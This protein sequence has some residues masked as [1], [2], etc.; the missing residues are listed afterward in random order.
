MRT[1]G[2]LAVAIVSMGAVSV[3]QEMPAFPP[4]APEHELLERFVGV[5]EM[6][7]ECGDG[8]GG[9]SVTNI[10]VI[11]GR[12]LGERWIVNEIEIEVEG[13]RVVGL[14]TIGFDPA[15]SKYVGTWSDSVQN[16]LWVYEGEYDPATRTLTLSTEGPNLMGDGAMAPFRDTYEF[17]DDDHIVSRSSALGED[18]QWV[19]FMSSDMRRKPE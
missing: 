17:V 4:S 11:R 9:A 13:S 14:Q 3:A 15:R 10:G 8:S 6:E 5:W 16:H 1:H 2:L 18:G 12:M 19:E 7:G